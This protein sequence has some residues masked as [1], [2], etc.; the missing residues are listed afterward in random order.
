MRDLAL[1][2]D[3]G[4]SGVRAAAVDADGQNACAF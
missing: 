1:G 2:I 3:V 4:T